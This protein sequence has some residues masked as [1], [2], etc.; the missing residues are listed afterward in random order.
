MTDFVV[1]MNMDFERGGFVVETRKLFEMRLYER[2]ESIKALVKYFIDQ[3]H[4]HTHNSRN[5]QFVC[6]H[7]SLKV[8]DQQT[9]D[10]RMQSADVV[11]V[12]V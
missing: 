6:L 11:D 2:G 5:R 4:T 9:D 8:S 3:V 1:G 7:W 12:G 10:D